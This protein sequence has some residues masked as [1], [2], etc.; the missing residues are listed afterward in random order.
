[1]EGSFQR[2][3]V[4]LKF[5][6]FDSLAVKRWRGPFPPSV[7]V[8]LGDEL[9]PRS[10]KEPLKKKKTIAAAAPCLIVRP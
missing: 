9:P 7:G 8:G 3:N 4:Q 2:L 10:I 6:A 1:M 5:D